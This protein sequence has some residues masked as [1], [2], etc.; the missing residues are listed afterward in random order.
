MMTEARGETMKATV[1]EEPKASSPAPLSSL[2]LREVPRPKVGDY[3]VLCELLYG[4]TCT[5]TDLHIIEGSFPFPVDYPT[6]LGHES[7]GRAVEVGSKVRHFQLGDL[8]TRVGAPPL[9]LEE[10]KGESQKLNVNWG[11]F[12]QYGIAK[13]HWAMRRDG[14]P[15]EEWNGYRVNQPLPSGIGPAE[16]TMVI[17]WRETLSYVT[18]MGLG[19]GKEERS[20][21]V[22]SGGV[23]LS[24]LNHARNLGL[25][26]VVMIGN[27]GREALARK[28]GATDFFNYKDEALTDKLEE[29]YPGG[30]DFIIDAVGKKGEAD[31]V[32]PLLKRGGTIGI[33]GIDDLGG[34]SLTPARSRGSFTYYNDHYDEEE[35]HHR[36]VSQMR[37]GKL[38]AQH[39][40]NLESPFPLED[41]ERA[42]RTV[43]K[44]KE[45]KALIELS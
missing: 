23:G 20:L 4:A 45:V 1:V 6:I 44:R 16:A 22:G 34:N 40:L 28:V 9:T 27:V 29:S 32:L 5:A 18:R 7:I 14:L 31:K 43:K 41:M 15:S 33:Y 30:F 13:D 25:E 21:I 2:S 42:F 38:K 12:A 39:W 10:E 36:V 11:G 8:I 24:F 26:K 37:A 17:T 3:D 19:E 35:S